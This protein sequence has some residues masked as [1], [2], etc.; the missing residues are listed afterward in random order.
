MRLVTFCPRA[1]YPTADRLGAMQGR[2]MVVDLGAAYRAWLISSEQCEKEAASRLASVLLPGDMV[3]FLETGRLGMEAAER[4]IEFARQ[5]PSEEAIREGERPMYPIESVHLLAPIRRPRCLRD[6]L[7]F[8]EH[9]RNVRRGRGLEIPPEWYQLPVYYKGNPAT[10]IGPDAPV[11]WP[12]FTQQ[13]DYELEFACVIGRGG[14]NI[15]AGEAGNFIAG[16]T[17]M[18]DF[19]ARDIQFKEMAAGLGP[20]KGKDFATALG[21]CLVTDDEVPDPY[22]LKMTARVNGEVWS[23]G[24]S[25]AISRQFPELIAHASMDE[26]LSAGDVLGSGTVGTGC[27]LELGRYLNVGDVVELEVEGLGILRNT[28]VKGG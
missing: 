3:L 8:E 21:P 9:V 16:Y 17:I 28:V 19:S 1:Q 18:N 2:R 26:Q 14:R 7:A 10:I 23:S 6:F 4:A 22:N 13:L 5:L 11:V 12:R 20:A 27:G 15:P 25:G 24:N